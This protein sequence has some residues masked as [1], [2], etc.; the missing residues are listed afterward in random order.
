MNAIERATQTRRELNK[1]ESCLKTTWMTGDC[2]LVS[3]SIEKD[4]QVES[5]ACRVSPFDSK[6]RRDS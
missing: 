6:P 1:L 2:D 4:A 3:R 5:L